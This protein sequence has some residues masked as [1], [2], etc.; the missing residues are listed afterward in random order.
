MIR[1]IE[2]P[3]APVLGD[4]TPQ[5]FLGLALT[6]LLV[7]SLLV[8]LAFLIVHTHSRNLPRRAAPPQL[9]ASATDESPVPVMR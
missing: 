9:D 3:Q 5:Y 2:P 4:K 1:L 7:L 8:Y 6:T